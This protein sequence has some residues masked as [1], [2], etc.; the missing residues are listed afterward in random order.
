MSRKL[1]ILS[2]ATLLLSLLSAPA[3]SAKYSYTYSVKFV[4]GY[5]DSNVG[6]SS[7]GEREGEPS[8]KFGNYA[9]EINIVNADANRITEE[10]KV[11]KSILVFVEKGEP[12][13]REPKVVEAKKFDNIAL[14]AMTGT[15]DDCN[16]IGE[17]LWGKS[18]NPFPLTIGYL[19]Y[20]TT[21]PLEVT[22][23]YTAQTCSHWLR[24][25][26]KLEC[27]DAEGRSQG[28]SV[29]IDVEQIAARKLIE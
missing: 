9:T 3:A 10:A 16:K 2:A 23:V 15:M 27:L 18:P 11:D 29:S 6:F 8:V 12:V 24:S 19:V 5:N 20:A 28:V 14:R 4:C 1:C 17:V 22:A 13:G 26:E 7:R 21:Q 25:P